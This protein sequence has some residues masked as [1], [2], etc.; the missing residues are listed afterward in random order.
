MGPFPVGST[1]VVRGFVND[2][3]VLRNFIY[4]GEV[5]E[6]LQY[7]NAVLNSPLDWL[8]LFRW[9]RLAGLSLADALVRVD[10]ESLPPRKRERAIDRLV[11]KRL[12]KQQIVKTYKDE[13]NRLLLCVQPDIEGPPK[14]RRVAIAMRSLPD[15]LTLVQLDCAKKALQA[16]YA[17]ASAPGTGGDLLSLVRSAA[18]RLDEI[19]NRPALA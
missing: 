5:A 11:G 7:F 3:A 6:P 16:A 13:L 10:E 19:E 2:S 14:L 8:P 9:A 17:Y 12:A 18:S 1:T 4:G 15:T